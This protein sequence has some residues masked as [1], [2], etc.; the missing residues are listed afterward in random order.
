MTTAL[1][2]KVAAWGILLETK[3]LLIPQIG[4]VTV[5]TMNMP[6]M[7]VSPKMGVLRAAQ[8]AGKTNAQEMQ[9]SWSSSIWVVSKV[10]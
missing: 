8:V 10:K 4:V 2:V 7:N 3:E 9:K 5:K 1:V 6:G